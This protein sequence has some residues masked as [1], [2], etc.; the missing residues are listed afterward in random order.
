MMIVVVVV[1]IFV[2]T[3]LGEMK[4]ES[5]AVLSVTAFLVVP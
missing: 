4:F 1:T 2:A 3:L 5:R